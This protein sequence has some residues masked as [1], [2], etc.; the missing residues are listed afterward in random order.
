MVAETALHH[1]PIHRAGQVDV[2][3]QEDYVLTLE[4]CDALVDLHEMG[5]HLK[6]KKEN[7]EQALKKPRVLKNIT[8]SREP[9][10][11]QEAPGQGQL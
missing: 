2:R 7:V 1:D 6:E 11:L 3:G 10:H 5:H 4:G 8:C 9:C